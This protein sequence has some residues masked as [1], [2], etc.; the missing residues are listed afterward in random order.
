MFKRLF[1]TALVLGAA[2]LAPPAAQAQSGLS[3]TAQPTAGVTCAPR[4]QMIRQLEK[5]F[6]ETKHGVGLVSAQQAFELWSSDRTGSWTM[7]VS[8]AD[9]M[10]CIVASGKAWHAQVTPVGQ[11]A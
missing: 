11:P 6:G 8:R 4:A 7:L 9:G 5:K 10:S 2:A 3:L 1:A